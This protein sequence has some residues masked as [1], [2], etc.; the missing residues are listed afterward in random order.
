MNKDEVLKKDTFKLILLVCGNNKTGKKSIVNKWL[1]N[2]EKFEDKKTFYSSISFKL[3]ENIN[4]VE[5]EIPSEIRILN[6]EEIETDLNTN[7]SF[8]KNALGAF[9]I[10]SILDETSFLE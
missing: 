7:S 10:N 8:Y 2:I 1:E 6:S 5:I 3:K 4:N 9:V